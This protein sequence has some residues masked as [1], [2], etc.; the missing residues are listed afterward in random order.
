[1]HYC[2]TVALIG[3]FCLG[4]CLIL[5]FAKLVILQYSQS[6]HDHCKVHLDMLNY[7]LELFLRRFPLTCGTRKNKI[8]QKTKIK[9]SMS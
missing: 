1:M 9:K 5:S 2:L 6:R 7:L 4:K 8:K 3:A